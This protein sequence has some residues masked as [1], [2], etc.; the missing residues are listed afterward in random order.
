MKR[1][2]GL[3]LVATDVEWTWGDGPEVRGTGEALLV[4][5]TGRPAALDDLTGDG[6]PSLRSRCS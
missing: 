1:A 3:R 4:A 5:L 2:H 6:V